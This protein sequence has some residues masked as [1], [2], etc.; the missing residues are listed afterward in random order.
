[1]TGRRCSRC[2]S[3]QPMYRFTGSDGYCAD[4]RLDSDAAY[5]QRHERTTGPQWLPWDR[6][7][8]PN[9]SKIRSTLSLGMWRPEDFDRDPDPYFKDDGGRKLHREGI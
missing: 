8:N 4:C 6:E 7:I 1:M 9:L 2:R 5:R 3:L